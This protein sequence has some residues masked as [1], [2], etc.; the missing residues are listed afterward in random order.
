MGECCAVSCGKGATRAGR[1][2]AKKGN[3]LSSV[4]LEE[5]ANAFANINH[6]AASNR[7][8]EERSVQDDSGLR[9]VFTFFEETF[10]QQSFQSIRNQPLVRFNFRAFLHF[11]FQTWA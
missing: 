9:V 10:P 6:D 8:K 7:P 11:F 1:S 4:L 3:Q 5:V 2:A